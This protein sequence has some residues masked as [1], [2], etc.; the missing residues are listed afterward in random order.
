MNKKKNY[1][2]CSIVVIIVFIICLL[3]LKK[4]NDSSNVIMQYRLIT[5]KHSNTMLNDGGSHINQYY[6]I[7]FDKR[8]VVKY[9]DKYK[10]LE[11]YIYKRKKLYE[12]K[13]ST[14][15]NKE[16][17]TLINKI[18][19]NKGIELDLPSSNYNYYALIDLSVLNKEYNSLDEF[20]KLFNTE[21]TI[22]YNNYEVINS[23]EELLKQ[24]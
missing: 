23:I 14:S 4:T 10:G 21:G 9:E 24:E 11:G 22:V 6:E 16:L 7:S 2:I 20:L 13:L 1:V 8:I 3:F 17:Q 15:D 18:I 12:K 19:D 5:D